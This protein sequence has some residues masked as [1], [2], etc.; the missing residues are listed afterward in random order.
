MLIVQPLFL[1]K[2]GIDCGRYVGDML[3]K[4]AGEPAA[5][6]SANAKGV[7]NSLPLLAARRRIPAQAFW[8]K[9][10]RCGT[11]PISKISDNEHTLAALGQSEILSVKYSVGEPI[12]DFP[13]ARE[14]GTKVPSPIA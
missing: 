14:D 6:V 3:G 2:S 4:I 7:G 12:P 9:K 8:L 1:P 5:L 11:S 13:Q 10:N